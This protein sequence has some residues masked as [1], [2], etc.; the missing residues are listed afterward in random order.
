VVRL[1]VLWG[2]TCHLISVGLNPSSTARL[3]AALSRGS[4]FV[5]CRVARRNFTSGRSQNRAG[6]SRFTR[7]P[8]FGRCHG[9]RPSEQR[10]VG[11]PGGTGQTNLVP[12]WSDGA[13]A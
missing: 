1:R 12:L 8:M 10:D 9:I 5:H 4:G 7:L 2:P 13:S 6:T 3:R 11:S